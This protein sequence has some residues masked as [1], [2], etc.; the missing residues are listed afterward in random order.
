MR[1]VSGNTVEGQE[2]RVEGQ[3]SDFG[4]RISDFG[5]R[6]FNPQSAICNPQSSRSSRLAARPFS[7]TRPSTLDPRPAHRGYTLVELLVVIM[8]IGILAALVLGVAAV[9]GETAREQ[10][11]RHVVERL[12]TLLTDFY[13]TFKTRR[14]KLNPA[15]EEIIANSNLKPAERGQAL[16]QARL[17]ALREMML[18]EIPDRWSDVLLNAVPTSNPSSAIA[19]QPIYLDT[20]GTSG[21][22]TLGRTPL[23]AAYL[24]RYAQIAA[25]TT[26]E[27]LLENQSAECLYM[28]ITMACGDGEARTLFGESTIGDT[29]GDGAPEFLDGWGHPISFLRWAPGFDSPIQQNANLLGDLD[30]KSPNQAWTSAA[31]GDHDPY[32]VFRA[33]AFAFR[34]VPL[35]YSAGR[36]EAY[37]I[38]NA[39]Q[40]VGSNQYVAWTGVR[41]ATKVS[42]KYQLNSLPLLLPYAK[43]KD[44]ADGALVYLGTAIDGTATDN[45]HNHLL[46]KR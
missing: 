27:K 35:V 20:T 30:I 25:N 34:L 15:V 39:E 9:A 29:D 5:L 42:L 4:F 22:V 16:A 19:M 8:I 21:P 41:D 3:K 38:R 18:M 43:V 37:G 7:G 33:N 12:H 17:Y 40:L 28:V 26:S 6:V 23:A 36:D 24:R 31:A 32:D 1:I 10:H 44:P 2:S 46:G 45:V 13:G 11:T 14:V